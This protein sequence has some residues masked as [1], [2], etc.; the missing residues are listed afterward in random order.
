[1]L[2][3]LK[4]QPQPVALYLKLTSFHDG[5]S[6]TGESRFPSLDLVSLGIV[7]V[8]AGVLVALVA[9]MLSMARSKTTTG[10]GGAIVIVGPIPIIF[11][12][13]KQSAKILLVLSIILVGAL[14]VLFVIQGYF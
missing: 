14:I 3:T 4:C 2:P 5:L 9:L 12:S 8:V 7:L 11:A 6:D 10:R 1:M 13:D